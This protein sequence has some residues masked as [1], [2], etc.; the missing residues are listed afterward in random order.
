M[1]FNPDPTKQAS[2]VLFSC[3]KSSP[4]HPQLIF[5]GTVVAKVNELKHFGFI[6]D[7]NLSFEKHLNEKIIKAKKI[8]GILKHLSKCLPLKTLDQIYKA[9]VRSHFD[10]CDIIYHIPSHQNQTPL[11]KTLNPLREKI[12]RVQYHAALAITGAWHGSSRS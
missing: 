3:K 12:E 7:S 8:V 5:N 2:E 1:E 10:S 9:L 11:G 4:N 6:L